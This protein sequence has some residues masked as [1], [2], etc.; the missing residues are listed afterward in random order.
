[1][2]SR[3]RARLAL[4]VSAAAAVI[5]SSPFVGDIR[6]SLLAAFP[7]QFQLIVGGAIGAA[8]AAALFA[9][10]LRIRDRRRWRFTGLAFAI[11]GAVAYAQLVA[12][13]NLLVDVV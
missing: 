4:A 6:S 5:L 12:T 8:V 10:V 3:Q 13:G 9:A 2:T 11:V 7:S 1:M